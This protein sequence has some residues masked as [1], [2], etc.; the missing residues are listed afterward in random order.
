MSRRPFVLYVK[1]EMTQG[2]SVTRGE[3]VRHQSPLRL[4]NLWTAFLIC[5][6]VIEN[7]YPA[8]TITTWIEPNPEPEGV[9]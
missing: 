5:V 8:R 3:A 6:S 4:R 2:G 9:L 7:V 1:V